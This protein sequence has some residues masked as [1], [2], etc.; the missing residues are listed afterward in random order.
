MHI[1]FLVFPLLAFMVSAFGHAQ[2][3][4]PVS[5]TVFK[6]QVAGKTVYS[7]APCLGA[8]QI[9][10]EPTRG[11]DQTSGRRQMGAD[12]MHERGRE[13][14]AE[15]LRPITG[16]DAKQLAVQGRRNKLSSESQQEC[17]RLDGEIST[18]QKDEKAAA[19][20]DL[21]DVQA[22]LFQKRSRFRELGC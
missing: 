5:R 12:V 19:G 8:K 11:L 13:A 4:P 7:D 21:K 22:K 3:L 14:F 18:A 17:R 10:V 20:P 9:N 1:R 16:M 15:A 6:C 2:S